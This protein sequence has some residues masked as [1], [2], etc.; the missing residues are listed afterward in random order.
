LAGVFFWLHNY[1]PPG[2]Y[3]PQVSGARADTPVRARYL[4]EVDFMD[5]QMGRLLQAFSAAAGLSSVVI[6]VADHGEGLGDHGEAEHGRLL[7]QATMHVPLV[8]V[9]PG[10]PAGSVSDRPV[11]T[12]RVYHTILDFA[13][14]AA[15]HSLRRDDEEAPLGEAMNP[16]LEYGW[17]PQVMTVAGTLK[18]ILSRRV[19][20]YDLRTD[21]GETHDLGSGAALPIAARKALDDYPVPSPDAARAPEALDQDAQR[22][23]AALGYVGGSAAPAVRRDAP[24]PADMTALF[25]VMNDAA[26]LFGSGKYAE[27]IPV[28]QKILAADPNNLDAALRLATSYSSIGRAADAE[29]AFRKAAAISPN[30]QDVRTYLAL[31]YART[32]DWARAIPLLEQVVKE[33]P[34]RQTAVDALGGLKVREGLAAMD[35]G[36]TSAATAAFERARALQGSAFGH[37]LDLGVLYMDARRFEDARVALDRALTATPDDAMALFKRA[38]VSVLLN[39][40]DRN[41]RIELARR[42]ADETTRALIEREKLF[43]PRTGT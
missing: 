29:A 41:A 31:H 38:Q 14:L 8:I 19:E 5:E 21:A 40:P 39:E 11:S 3:A 25:P 7:Y 27:A 36:D 43:R 18:A 35:R 13:G 32:S 20:T 10:V 4:G 16:F 22:R 26:A 34:D 15:E 12:R 1:Y 6:V 33:S 9:G 23:L 42:K 37:D 30:S 24:R 28:L 17:Q 2:R